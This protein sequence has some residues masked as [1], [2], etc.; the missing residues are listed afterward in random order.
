MATQANGKAVKT[1]TSS[2]ID[3]AFISISQLFTNLSNQRFILQY[4]LFPN[5]SGRVHRLVAAFI[6]TLHCPRLY[7][8]SFEPHIA[9]VSWFNDIYELGKIHRT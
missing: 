1:A 3:N 8:A 9:E 2:F 5:L 6:A 7:S 4:M